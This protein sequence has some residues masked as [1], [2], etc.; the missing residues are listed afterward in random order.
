M[1]WLMCFAIAFVI[2]CCIEYPLLWPICIGNFI[3]WFMV[4]QIPRLSIK[5]KRCQAEIHRQAVR[6]LYE[7]YGIVY[8]DRTP[9]TNN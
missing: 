6:N 4:A 5:T 9:P 8:D 3:G 2:T 7:K 1:K